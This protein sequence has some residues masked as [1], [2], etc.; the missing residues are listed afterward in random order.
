MCLLLC[1]AMQIETSFNVLGTSLETPS[2]MLVKPSRRRSTWSLISLGRR[3][4]LGNSLARRRLRLYGG[5]AL[6]YAKLSFAAAARN[7]WLSVTHSPLPNV[8]VI[9]RLY[10]SRPF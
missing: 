4:M 2:D 5:G 3:D 6:F 1:H 10:R 9:F 8:S 7:Q